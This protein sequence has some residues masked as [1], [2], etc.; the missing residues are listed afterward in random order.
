MTKDLCGLAQ[1]VEVKEVNSEQFLKAIR[2]RLDEI[3]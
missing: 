3:L 1:G 2:E